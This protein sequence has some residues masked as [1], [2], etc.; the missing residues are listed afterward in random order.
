M[1]AP[2]M[3]SSFLFRD[4]ITEVCPVLPGDQ[5][6]QD[7]VPRSD[8]NRP[9]SLMGPLARNSGL[10]RSARGFSGCQGGRARCHTRSR[11]WLA[12]AASGRPRLLSAWTSPKTL[13]VLSV[14]R[15]PPEQAA[16]ENRAPAAMPF[17]TSP[18]KPLGATFALF[19]PS[20]RP[21]LTRRETGPDWLTHHA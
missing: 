15:P 13:S 9:L 21:V 4:C 19:S 14:W 1:P 10:D 3:S 18:R 2:S 17:V 7:V 20:H 12:W 5:L 6:F 16:R 11:A 8:R